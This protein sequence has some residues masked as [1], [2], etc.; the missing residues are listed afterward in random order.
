MKPSGR[1]KSPVQEQV[2]TYESNAGKQYESKTNGGERVEKKRNKLR[3]GVITAV[4]IDII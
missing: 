2:K 4:D 3:H 1:Q